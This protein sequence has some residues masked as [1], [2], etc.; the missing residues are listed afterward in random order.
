MNIEQQIPVDPIVQRALQ[1][2]PQE[3]LFEGI[4]GWVMSIVE[5]VVGF[6]FSL[7]PNWNLD[8]YIR[9]VYHFLLKRQIVETVQARDEAKIMEEDER[10]RK[11]AQ[12]ADEIKE[13]PKEITEEDKDEWRDDEVFR[14]LKERVT[15]EL[16]EHDDKKEN[17]TQPPEDSLL[18]TGE[19][20]SKE[21]LE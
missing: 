9:I 10:R 5:I 19:G 4:K 12:A 7:P 1:A 20:E 3:P 6:I 21:K 8:S 16:H 18:N 15:E 13:E 17:K 11:A 2:H 14:D